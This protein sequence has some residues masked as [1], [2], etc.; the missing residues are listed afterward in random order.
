MRAAA[1][2]LVGLGIA[3]LGWYAYTMT[4]LVFS[5]APRLYV[6]ASPPLAPGAPRIHIAMILPITSKGTQ[7][8]PHN[9]LR[10]LVAAKVFWPAFLDTV[11]GA[12]GRFRYTVYYGVNATDAP[13][14]DHAVWA[15]FE[16]I[17]RPGTE[18]PG[19]APIAWSKT[20]YSVQTLSQMYNA[21]AAR[22]LREGADYFYITNDDTK[23]LTRGWS[24]AFVQQLERSP[25]GENIGTT[26]PQS[27]GECGW[28]CVGGH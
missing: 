14:L 27:Y 5:V 4:D 21:L 25:A 1:G 11:E 26:G 16:S 18:A 8:R 3:F 10:E 2:V 19:A 22:A 23:M 17:M 28:D 7:L 15:E 6:S 24:E 9:V 20:V 12:E 13:L